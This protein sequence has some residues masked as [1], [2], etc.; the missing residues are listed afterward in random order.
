MVMVSGAPAGAVAGPSARSGSAAAVAG[1][2]AAVVPAIAW[3]A[4]PGTSPEDCDDN[5]ERDRE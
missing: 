2:V 3:M 5:S 4:P 1:A